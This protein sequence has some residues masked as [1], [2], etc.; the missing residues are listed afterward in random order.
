M[1]LVKNIPSKLWWSK[2]MH[3]W[4]LYRHR[5]CNM[6]FDAKRIWFKWLKVSSWFDFLS[7]LSF[8]LKNM[9]PLF[10]GFDFVAHPSKWWERYV[11]IMPRETM[12]FWKK[13][14]NDGHFRGTRISAATQY[15]SA[16]KYDQTTSKPF[17]WY[18]VDRKSVV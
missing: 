4:I 16:S 12:S 7:N 10:L 2:T 15:S 6:K 18:I 5:R 17:I 14:K 9:E 13:W 1:K 8:S 11:F 3:G